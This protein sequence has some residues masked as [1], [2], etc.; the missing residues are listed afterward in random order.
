MTVYEHASGGTVSDPAYGDIQH[1]HPVRRGFL[2]AARGLS[3]FVYAWVVLVEVVLVTGFFLL[4]FGA[5]PS[6]DFVEWTYRSLDRAMEPFRGIFTP[7]EL[8]TTPGNQVDSIFETSVLFAM[9]VY[10]LLAL[11]MDAAL[12]WLG[13]RLERMDRA[14]REYELRRRY[15]ATAASSSLA[16]PSGSPG[17]PETAGAAATATRQGPES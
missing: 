14:D 10:G 5:N 4:L 1:R 13:R 3:Y 16:T 6:S 17:A 9:I 2:L 15:E 11:A 7:I 12:D 8:G